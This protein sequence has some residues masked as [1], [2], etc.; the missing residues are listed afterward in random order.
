MM[1]Y[2][3]MAYVLSSGIW[4]ALGCIRLRDVLGY[5]DDELEQAL[6]QWQALYDGQFRSCPYQ[7]DWDRFNETGRSLTER[8]R[9]KLPPHSEVVYE[10]SDDRE[11]FTPGECMDADGCAGQRINELALREQKRTLVHMGGTNRPF[12]NESFSRKD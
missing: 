6:E 2:K 3:V 5:H 1:K 9:K 4:D 11:F 10:P 12:F 8:I 7:F